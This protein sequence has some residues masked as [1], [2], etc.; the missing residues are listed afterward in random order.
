L[1]LVSTLGVSITP[2]SS[3]LYEGPDR[4][5]GERGQQKKEQAQTWA[6]SLGL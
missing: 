3:A 2:I 5:K 4:G 1:T 6:M